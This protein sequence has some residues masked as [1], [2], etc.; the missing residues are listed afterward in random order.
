M[1]NSGVGIGPALGE[2]GSTVDDELA[3][4]NQTAMR[5]QQRC[6]HKEIFKDRSP[7]GTDALAL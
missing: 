1:A 5:G 4:T 2:D 3:R 7:C 6:Q